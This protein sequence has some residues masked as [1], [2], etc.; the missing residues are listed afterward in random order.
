[1]LSWINSF[2]EQ[3]RLS[4]PCKI[5]FTSLR[6]NFRAITQHVHSMTS[7]NHSAR[8]RL[9]ISQHLPSEC[10]RRGKYVPKIGL[11][12]A[13]AV[14]LLW[15]FARTKNR[16]RTAVDLRKTKWAYYLFQNSLQFNVPGVLQNQPFIERLIVVFI[17][18]DVSQTYS[19]EMIHI[20]FRIESSRQEC[21]K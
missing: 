17:I 19:I 8:T 2:S 1:M 14:Q 20:P 7:N 16:W 11:L 3:N 5:I 15:S 9:F 12:R 21:R 18:L 13:V 6:A 10:F 4:S